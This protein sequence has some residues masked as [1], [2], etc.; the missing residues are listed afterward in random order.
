MNNDIKLNKFLKK[1]FVPG[2][3]SNPGLCCCRLDAVTNGPHG[4]W[5][6]DEKKYIETGPPFDLLLGLLLCIKSAVNN[7]VEI[8]SVRV[9]PPC[10]S[11]VI[12]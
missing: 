9:P 8:R 1:K 10:R 7:Q 4:C 2:G 3:D 5:L 6:L 12:V 11:I